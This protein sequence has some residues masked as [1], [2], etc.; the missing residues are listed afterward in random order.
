MRLFVRYARE[1]RVKYISHLDLMRTFQ[2]A[3][4]RAHIPVAYSTGFNPHPRLAFASALAVGVTSSDEY[5]DTILEEPMV[6]GEF[7]AR[8]NSVMPRDCRFWKQS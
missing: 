4:R 2:R 8:M 5:M 6:P 1:E 7:V 3:L